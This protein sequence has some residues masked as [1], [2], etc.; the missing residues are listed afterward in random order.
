MGSRTGQGQE[1]QCK[2]VQGHIAKNCKK[3]DL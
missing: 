2:A 3:K 1:G